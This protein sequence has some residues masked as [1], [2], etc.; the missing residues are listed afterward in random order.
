MIETHIHLDELD[1]EPMTVGLLSLVRRLQDD[2]FFF[3]I[4]RLNTFQVERVNDL[5]YA[6]SYF[7]Y[8]FPVFRGYCPERKT[9]YSFISNRSSEVLIQKP[10]TELFAEESNVKF[11]LN[12]YQEIEYLIKTS[13][14]YPDLSLLLMPENT[15]FAIKEICVEATDELYT[16]LNYYE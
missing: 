3:H 14:S 1:Q 15:T 10:V 8:H 9:E 13:D 11:L 4:N 2:E 6:G 5:V 16:I 7:V 12:S